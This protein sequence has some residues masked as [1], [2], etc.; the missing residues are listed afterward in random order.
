MSSKERSQKIQEN[1]QIQGGRRHRRTA[2][3]PEPLLETADGPGKRADERI[4]S[5][6]IDEI[7]PDRYQGRLR[8]PVDLAA[9]ERLYNGEWDA[10][11][12]LDFVAQQRKEAA[13]PAVD[14]AWKN[15]I[16]LAQSILSEGQVAPVTITPARE[17][18]GLPVGYRY[19]IET[20]E[21]R[22]WAYQMMRWLLNN[23]PGQMVLPSEEWKEDPAFIRAVAISQ[24]SRLRQVAEN[25]QRQSY[26]SAV[27]RAIAYASMLAEDANEQ[28]AGTPPGIREGL[29]ELPTAYWRAARR[30][31]RGHK[32]VVKQLPTGERQIQRHLQ[33]LTS[34]DAW[35]LAQAK[36]HGLSEAQLRPLVKKSV[37]EQ[38]QV[39]TLVVTEQLSSREVEALSSTLTNDQALSSEEMLQT[40]RNASES[41]AGAK[42]KQKK[43]LTLPEEVARLLRSITR[44]TSRYESLRRQVND[45]QLVALIEAELRSY[46]ESARGRQRAKTPRRR[47]KKLYDLLAQLEWD[48]S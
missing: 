1:W 29:L 6:S 7:L 42:K 25:E 38:R 41:D 39:V 48:E 37:E 36:Q 19:V 10:Q 33:L 3:E 23:N 31:L 44:A 11:D 43:E 2:P 34:L 9:I 26:P 27:D 24:A 32:S 14:E 8:W 47:L 40:L 30:G 13:S 21:G 16:E 4:M 5:V 22:F 20:G 12:F 45:N 18:D 17:G 15:T 35:V 28:V 46:D